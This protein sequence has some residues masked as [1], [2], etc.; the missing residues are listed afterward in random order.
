M[1]QQYIIIS[2]SCQ[3]LSFGILKP[4]IRALVSEKL[5]IDKKYPELKSVIMANNYTENEY[6]SHLIII[7]Y[8]QLKY[9]KPVFLKDTEGMRVL[10]KA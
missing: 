2:Y 10:Y 8:T 9:G 1:Q 6:N 7:K 4:H 3:E 5:A